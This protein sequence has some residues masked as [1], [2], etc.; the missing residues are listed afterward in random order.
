MIIGSFQFENL[1]RNRVPFHL[2]A[3]QEA[4][5]NLGQVMDR[6]QIKKLLRCVSDCE[7]LQSL[8]KDAQ[9]ST[10]DPFVFVC[11]TGQE[12]RILKQEWEALGYINSCVVD[13]GWN[14][15]EQEAFR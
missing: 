12:S 3:L 1:I 10:Q 4:P 9:W 5:S 6:V 14:L 8:A 13:G 11:K 15:L 2:I 7:T